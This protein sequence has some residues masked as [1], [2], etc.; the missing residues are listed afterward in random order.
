[1]C[2]PGIA[3]SLPES[4]TSLNSFGTLTLTT[5]MSPF[6]SSPIILETHS[7]SL[8][9]SYNNYKYFITISEAHRRSK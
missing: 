2:T 4:M 5:R 7:I 3:K 6:A 1:M 8:N 9:L